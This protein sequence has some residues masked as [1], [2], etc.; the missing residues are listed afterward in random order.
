VVQRET[1]ILIGV[2][3]FVPALNNYELL[4]DFVPGQ[5]ANPAGRSALELGLYYAI[6]PAHQRQGY[7]SEA[8]RALVAYA[9]DHLRLRRIVA[10]TTHDN[11]AS[12]GVMQ[13]LGMRLLRNTQPEPPWLQVVGVLENPAS[14]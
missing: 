1:G 6:A 7:A 2:A 11:A 4:A 5:A 12:Q 13:R 10:T 8:A 9:F 14:G 3:G